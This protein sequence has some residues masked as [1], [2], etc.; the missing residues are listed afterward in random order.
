M[1]G[2]VILSGLPE[3]VPCLVVAGILESADD[4]FEF[5]HRR[6]DAARSVRGRCSRAIVSTEW[7]WLWNM[8]LGLGDPHVAMG[9]VFVDLLLHF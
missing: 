6:P 3:H 8:A 1:Y 5:S 2:A 7:L 4:L 9:Y